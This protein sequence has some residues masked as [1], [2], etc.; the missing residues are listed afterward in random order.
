MWDDVH[1]SRC[2][3]IQTVLKFDIAVTQTLGRRFL[4]AL[5]IKNSADM[6]G[7]MKDPLHTVMHMML[8]QP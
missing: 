5:Q 4:I 6:P 1:S 7:Q 2:T 8:A 3:C